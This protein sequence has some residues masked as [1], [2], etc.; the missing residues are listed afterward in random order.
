MLSPGFSSRVRVGKFA[1]FW[2]KFGI[3]WPNLGNFWLP[4]SRDG[5]GGGKGGH[6]PP[7]RDPRGQIR[8]KLSECPGSRKSK[9]LSE[10]DFDGQDF[11]PAKNVDISSA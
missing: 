7:R 11:S 6:C 3:F 2:S 4:T 8:A 10:R 5:D 9:F 1:K